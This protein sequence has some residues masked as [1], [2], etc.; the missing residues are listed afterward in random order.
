MNT[1][2]VPVQASGLRP[3]IGV[4][5]DATPLVTRPAV[6]GFRRTGRG[7]RFA[8]AC[9]AASGVMALGAA[10]LQIAIDQ[11]AHVPGR[12]MLWLFHALGPTLLGLAV[13]AGLS[14]RGSR[15]AQFLAWSLVAAVALP[16]TLAA[17]QLPTPDGLVTRL[18]VG[19]SMLIGSWALARSAK[20]SSERP[21]A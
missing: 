7:L 9:F 16:A 21:A 18:V 19:A 8:V 15:L 11:Q 4:F 10:L 1:P 12:P 17:W 20:S 3:T 2:E 14:A 6:W 5:V 13:T